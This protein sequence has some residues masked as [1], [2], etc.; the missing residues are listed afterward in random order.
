MKIT[1]ETYSEATLVDLL[2]K[3]EVVGLEY[4]YDNYSNALYGII[5]N[6]VRSSDIADEVLQD[7]FLKIWNKSQDYDATKGRL[8]TWMLRLTRNLAIDKIRSKEIKN[9]NRT[10]GMEVVKAIEHKNSVLANIEN[11]GFREQLLVLPKEQ[12]QVIDWIYYQGYSHSEV[13][14]KY[15]IPIG[16]VK[17]RVRSALGKLRKVIPREFN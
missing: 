11:I 7:A 10:D 2:Q 4:L 6:I 9:A 1:K 15:N 17:T 5:I 3:K 16:T 13:A 8:F 12:I 14:K